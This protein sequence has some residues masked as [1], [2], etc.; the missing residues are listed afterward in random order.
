M[1]KVVDLSLACFRKLHGAQDDDD[2]NINEMP[3]NDVDPNLQQS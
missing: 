1:E 3:D 2:L